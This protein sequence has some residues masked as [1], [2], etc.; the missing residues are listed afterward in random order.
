MNELIRRMVNAL[1]ENVAESDETRAMHDELMNNC[2]EHFRD[3]VDSGMDEKDAANAVMESL[4]GMQE[5]IDQY[6]RKQAEAAEP[7][8]EAAPA[9]EKD[10]GEEDIPAEKTVWP[11]AGIGKIRVDAA[12]FDVE[13]TGAEGDEIRIWS[14]RPERIEVLRDSEVLTVRVTPRVEH[15]AEEVERG[16]EEEAE[17]DGRGVLDMSLNE[18]L[19]K[20]KK[21]VSGVVERVSET[22]GRT[23][24]C[25]EGKLRIRVP[26]NLLPVLEVN[27]ASGNVNVEKTHAPAYTLRTASGDVTLDASVKDAI[28]RLF[29]SAA[30][31]DIRVGSI[32][33]KEADVSSISG[34]VELEGDF[35]DLKCKSVSGD[36]EFEGTAQNL[37]SRSVSGDVELNLSNAETGSISADATSGDVEVNL[38]DN[39]GRA[40]AD[41]SST[42]GEV[43]CEIDD[44]GENAPLKIRVRT[45]SGDISVSRE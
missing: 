43:T 42:V 15:M 23:G 17:N 1:F 19:G 28:D 22:I 44:A 39:C 29:I 26:E 18:L 20:V 7:A 11:T 24:I 30:S 32:F 4:N 41:C 13:V 6:P 27:T 9:E 38:L 45:V 40:H 36:V 16:L 33:A 25:D 3:L 34:D 14:D 8:P 37:V 5:V 10:E 35:G 2:Q 21:M 31:G 12:A